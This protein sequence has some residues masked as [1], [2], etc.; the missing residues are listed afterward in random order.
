MIYYHIA[1][2]GGPTF[3]LIT[4]DEIDEVEGII[5]DCADIVDPMSDA[6]VTFYLDDARLVRQDV[7][8]NDEGDIIF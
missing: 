7:V 2:L 1:F 6:D 8:Y 3:S 5:G 4:P